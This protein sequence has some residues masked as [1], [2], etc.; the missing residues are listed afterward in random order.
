MTMA[1][2]VQRRT[3]L[4]ASAQEM[5]LVSSNGNVIL[6]STEPIWRGAP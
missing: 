5:S 3:R 4:M 2:G 1:S 6:M